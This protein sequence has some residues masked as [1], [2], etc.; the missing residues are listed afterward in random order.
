MVQQEWDAPP[1]TASFD[2]DYGELPDDTAWDPDDLYPDYERYENH[3]YWSFEGPNWCYPQDQILGMRDDLNGVP[4]HLRV[5]F[6]AKNNTTV[7]I[8][9]SPSQSDSVVPGSP[10]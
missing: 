3:T 4:L 8:T 7:Q 9:L 2:L 10:D 5:N 1:Y 6:R